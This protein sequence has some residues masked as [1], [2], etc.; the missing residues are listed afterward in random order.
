MNDELISSAFLVT[1]HLSPVTWRNMRPAGVE[2]TAFG[3]GGQ[4][5]IQLSYGRATAGI[6]HRQA[7]FHE[8]SLIGIFDLRFPAARAKMSARHAADAT[9]H[10]PPH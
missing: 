7:G 1:R 2:P 5:S 6:S 9:H 10:E 8:I 4:R 3:S